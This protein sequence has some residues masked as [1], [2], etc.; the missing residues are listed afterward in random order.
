MAKRVR[1]DVHRAHVAAYGRQK[2][3]NHAAKHGKQSRNSQRI[4]ELDE[5]Q[6]DYLWQQIPRF[7]NPVGCH[8]MTTNLNPKGYPVCRVTRS[9]VATANMRPDT[10]FAAGAVMLVYH[11]HMPPEPT[12]D[13]SHLCGNPSCVRL[14]HLVWESRA[15]NLARIACTGTICCTCNNSRDFCPHTPKCI[16][17]RYLP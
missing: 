14:E 4:M 11:G 9:G 7:D 5:D 2:R 17:T 6:L 1:S 3:A 15:A 13:C 10:R 16:K 12:S 8:I